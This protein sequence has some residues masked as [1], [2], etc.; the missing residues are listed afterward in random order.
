MDRIELAPAAQAGGDGR[1]PSSGRPVAGPADGAATEAQDH[2]ITRL[3]SSW[4]AGERDAAETFMPLVYDELRRIA[5]GFFRNERSD[6]TLQPTEI[7]HEVFITLSRRDDIR[8]IDRSHFFGLAACLM[9]RALVDHA[10]T[11][12]ATKRGG[13]KRPVALDLLAGLSDRRPESM[14]ALDDALTDLAKLDPA[15]ALVVELRFFGGLSVDEVAACSGRSPRTVA[16]DWQRAKA[17]LYR[18]LSAETRS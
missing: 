10:R 12:S 18:A 9:R 3:L 4:S 16:R 11:R 2:T 17:V 5:R 1:S 13:G 14:V 6:H 8:W 7:V 15:K